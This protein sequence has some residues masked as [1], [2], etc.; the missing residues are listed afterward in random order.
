MNWEREGRVV[1]GRK[2]SVSPFFLFEGGRE[3]VS[4]ALASIVQVYFLK[5][6]YTITTVQD[7]KHLTSKQKPFFCKCVR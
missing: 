6:S 5:L 3:R 7:V 1:K 2:V 4:S